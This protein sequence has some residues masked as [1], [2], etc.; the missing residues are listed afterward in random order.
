MLFR[1]KCA[2]C[3]CRLDIQGR[4]TTIDNF[5]CKAL[6]PE[7]VV[8]WDNLLPACIHC[9][10]NK[11]KID[12]K[13][14]SIIDPS[15][16]NPKDYLYLSHYMIRSKDNSLNS[17]GRRTIE[18]LQLNNRERLVWPRIEIADSLVHKLEEIHEKAQKLM[19]HKVINSLGISRITQ[20]ITDLLY[21]VQPQAEYSAFIS[22]II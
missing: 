8:S 18:E 22:A 6:Y 12:T 4:S 21:M 5:H 13:R 9:N 15:K 20:G 11:G 1:S 16:D 7:E 2:Y 3:E 10:A 19:L 17:K 14:Y